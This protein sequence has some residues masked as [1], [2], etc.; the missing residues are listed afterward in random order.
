M[1]TNSGFT[2]GAEAVAHD[3]GIA[4]H[5]VRPNFDY[6]GLPK[7]DRV[8]IRGAIGEISRSSD[9][10]IYMHQTNVKALDIDASDYL[11]DI[12]P[13]L[14][15]ASDQERFLVRVLSRR[16]KYLEWVISLVQSGSYGSEEDIPGFQLEI[17]KTRNHID[18]VLAKIKKP[19]S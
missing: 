19:D 12:E 18:E 10:P 6:T 2:A 4:L 17:T 3:E 15:C 11:V 1:I 14:G 5:V 8:A 9:L 7:I 13:L 16:L